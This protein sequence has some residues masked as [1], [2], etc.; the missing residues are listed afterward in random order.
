MKTIINKYKKRINE[1]T[2]SQKSLIFG[3]TWARLESEKL[4]LDRVISDLE[5]YYSQQSYESGWNDCLKSNGIENDGLQF[6]DKKF[7]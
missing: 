3:E 2:T 4:T 6:N 1:I 7:R 5:L